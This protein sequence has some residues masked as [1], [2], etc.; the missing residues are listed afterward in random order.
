MVDFIF[1]YV[2][3]LF[4]FIY[5]LR[6]ELVCIFFNKYAKIEW[7]KDEFMKNKQFKSPSTGFW[8]F[9]LCIALFVGM[10]VAVG[11]SNF[12]IPEVDVTY[13]S[14]NNWEG[15]LKINENKTVK[16]S[17]VIHSNEGTSYGAA[18]RIS[19]NSTVNLV[20]EGDNVLAGN[21]GIISAGIEVEEGS[22]VN[23]YGMDG[24]SLTV[25]G[26]KYSAGIGGIGYGSASATNPKAGNVIIYSGNIMA[27]GGDRG[28]GIGSGYHSSASN[29]EIKGGNVIALG[30]G[31]GAGI[32][33]GY[34][35]SGGAAV[36]AGVG[37]YNGGNIKISGRTS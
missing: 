4:I 24:S 13:N 14:D 3:I 10:I 26:G 32:G 28:A 11:E 20:F 31:S 21:S 6:R 7:N 30:T 1:I 17:G 9:S 25:T 12:P 5:K 23:I 19:D 18:I 8:I 29:I 34:G 33:S 15:T 36:A 37:F 2:Y 35:T 27:I 16:I 22:T